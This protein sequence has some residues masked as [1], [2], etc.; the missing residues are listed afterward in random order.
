MEICVNYD[1]LMKYHGQQ[2]IIFAGEIFVTI[3]FN[4]EKEKD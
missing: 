3:I 4:N 1:D 2:F